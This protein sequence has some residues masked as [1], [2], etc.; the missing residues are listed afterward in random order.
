MVVVC[1]TMI[2]GDLTAVVYETIIPRGSDR[3]CVWNHD[4]EGLSK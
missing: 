4:P 1:E 3:S 2:M